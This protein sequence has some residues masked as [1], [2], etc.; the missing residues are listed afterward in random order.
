MEGS[1]VRRSPDTQANRSRQTS[2]SAILARTTLAA[3][4]VKLSALKFLVELAAQADGEL[5]F[6]QRMRADKLPQH[7]RQK[8][9]HEILRRAEPQPAAQLRAR[10]IAL[11][12][13]VR[14]Q[15]TPGELD[16]GLAVGRHCH[17]MGIA[18]E[19]PASGFFLQLA[20]VLADRR[21]AQAK[22]LGGLGETPGL[23]D[24]QESLKQDGIEHHLFITNIRLQ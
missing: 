11:R 9:R 14:R 19:E 5:E 16:H 1:S 4:E 2:A 20:D 13:F 6:D 24:R 21:L 8:R 23:G 3:D 10:E 7:F 12:P 15:D 22:P 17:R 18:D